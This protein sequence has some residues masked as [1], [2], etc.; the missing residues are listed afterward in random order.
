[1]LQG[2]VYG[3]AETI[4]RQDGVNRVIQPGLE[5]VEQRL[6]MPLPLLQTRLVAQIL[7]PAL[8]PE[9]L[10]VE[11]QRLVRP[12]GLLEQIGG[13]RELAPRVNI[14]GDFRDPAAHE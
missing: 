10:P 7:D 12:A 8:D 4:F 6:A 5:L 2:I 9:Q 3:D 14:A 11:G 13:L 1:M